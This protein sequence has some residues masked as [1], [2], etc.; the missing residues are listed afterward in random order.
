MTGDFNLV[1]EPILDYYNYNNVTCNNQEAMKALLSLKESHGLL[2]PWRFKFDKRKRYTCSK[3][4]P[5]QKAR[6]DFFLVSSELMTFI[7]KVK[8]SP[9]YRSDH[10]MT[11]LYITSTKFER[12]KGF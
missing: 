5:S 3:S 8:R 12:G 11:E 6:L 2:D 1:Q 10:V 9:G 7:D 4:N